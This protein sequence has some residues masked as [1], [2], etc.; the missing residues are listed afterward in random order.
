MQRCA[1]LRRVPGA[2]DVLGP[3]DER[4]EETTVSGRRSWATAAA[5]C[6]ETTR[7]PRLQGR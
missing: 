1:A 4:A 6:L 5:G 7:R 3:A 2:A